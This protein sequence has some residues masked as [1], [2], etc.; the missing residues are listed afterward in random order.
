M[1]NI[2]SMTVFPLVQE[3]PWAQ[4]STSAYLTGVLLPL[5]PQRIAVQ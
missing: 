1:T 5:L 2:D 3:Y 4:T